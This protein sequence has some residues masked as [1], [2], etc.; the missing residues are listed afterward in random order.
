MND[1]QDLYYLYYNIRVLS[2]MMKIWI[3]FW[4]TQCAGLVSTDYRIGYGI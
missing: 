3:Q 4:I 2:K 1:N